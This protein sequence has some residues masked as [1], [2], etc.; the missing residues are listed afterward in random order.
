MRLSH[1]KQ[2]LHLPA[3]E[4]NN[5]YIPTVRTVRK[6]KNIPARDAKQRILSNF[7][8]PL[9]KVHNFVG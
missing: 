4:G 7:I 5:P 9:V 6:D 1:A 3:A 8:N 2:H